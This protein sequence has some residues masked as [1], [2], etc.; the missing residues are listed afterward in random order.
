MDIETL[1]PQYI[2]TFTTGLLMFF[3]LL[4]IGLFGYIGIVELIS[5]V[6]G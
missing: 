2:S 1:T 4:F 6:Q 5:W 3:I